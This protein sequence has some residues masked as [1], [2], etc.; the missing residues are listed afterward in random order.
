MVQGRLVND[1]LDPARARYIDSLQLWRAR[2][3]LGSY[4]F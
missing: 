1:T 3:G 4:A 2:L